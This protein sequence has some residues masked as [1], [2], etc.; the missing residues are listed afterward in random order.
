MAAS[1]RAAPACITSVKARFARALCFFAGFGSGW[2][3][4][5]IDLERAGIVRGCRCHP[6]LIPTCRV[7]DPTANVS[8]SWHAML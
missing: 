7:F 3:C 8:I 6:R 4:C 5:A 2:Q 1:L